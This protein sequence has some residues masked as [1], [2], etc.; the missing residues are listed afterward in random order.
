MLLLERIRRNNL[1]ALDADTGRGFAAG[2]IRTGLG[3]RVTNLAQHVVAFDQFAEASVL[4]G[5]NT[6]LWRRPGFHLPGRDAASRRPGSMPRPK[7]TREPSTG[8]HPRRAD[9][10]RTSR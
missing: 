10:T 8:P 2:A 5:A 3:R 9:R 7:G 6:R 4:A 1:D